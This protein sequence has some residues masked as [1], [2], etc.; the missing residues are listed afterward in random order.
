MTL[1]TTIF[2]ADHAQ[3]ASNHTQHWNAQQGGI[4]T[5]KTNCIELNDGSTVVLTPV[6]PYKHH[7]I[8]FLV[9][10]MAGHIAEYKI[11]I[12]LPDGLS[13]R[14]E[15]SGYATRYQRAFAILKKGDLEI[16]IGDELTEAR[17]QESIDGMLEITICHRSPCTSIDWIHCFIS[18]SS[19]QNARIYSL[20]VKQK[21][22][23]KN[24]R[25]YEK[26][27][28]NSS[29]HQ[30]AIQAVYI[31]RNYF[32]VEF[33]SHEPGKTIAGLELV[34]T[35]PFQSIHWLTNTHVVWDGYGLSPD[36]SKYPQHAMA[37]TELYG[38]SANSSRHT[39]YGICNQLVD[40]SQSSLLETKEFLASHIKIRYTD[41]STVDFPISQVDPPSTKEYWGRLSEYIRHIN[42]GVFIEVGG[43][44]DSSIDTRNRLNKNWKYISTD[45]HDGPNVDLVADAHHLSKYISSDFADVIYSVDVMEHLLAPWRF[46]IEANKVLKIGG[47]FYAVV[48]CTWP[49]HAEPW[50]F[51]RFS[52]HAWPALLNPD[53]GFEL[54]ET[55]VFGQSVTIPSLPIMVE[56]TLEQ[57]APAYEHTFVIAR[58]T[59]IC[60]AEWNAYRSEWT[61]GRY[62]RS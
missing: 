55:G 28:P 44:G 31:F 7:G 18:G 24:Y 48:P 38:S 12:D 10:F 39:L 35:I 25:L 50:D 34:S 1:L 26:S 51:W 15:I 6:D 30:Y 61:S 45:I 47:L 17:H 5:A 9:E 33:E 57:Y 4:T 11:K 36:Q 46:I 27:Q 59:G 43:R 16:E 3:V 49:L 56:N 22:Y 62:L 37:M 19:T 41:L 60:K 32:H 14:I 29:N 40:W 20:D 54:L 21:Q 8:S 52:D 2:S 53:T 13:A 58:K 23:N 42:S